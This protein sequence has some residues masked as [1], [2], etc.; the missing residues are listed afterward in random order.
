VVKFQDTLDRTFS[1][2]ADST[3]RDILRRIAMASMSIAQ[4]ANAYD[5]S[6]PA[7]MK[8]V[9]VLENAGLVK[10]EKI[11]RVRNCKLTSGPL[12]DASTWVDQYTKFWSTRLD[13]LAEILENEEK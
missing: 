11:G 6:L 3:R 2:L 8:H 4:I 1:A 9:A 12:V 13:R 7:V 10:T 5:M